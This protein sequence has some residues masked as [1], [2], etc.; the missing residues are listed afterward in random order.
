MGF[1]CR[2]QGCDVGQ[3][4]NKIVAFSFISGLRIFCISFLFLEAPKMIKNYHIWFERIMLVLYFKLFLLFLFWV[5]NPVGSS[6]SPIIL[7]QLHTCFYSSE[8]RIT[9]LYLM[10]ELDVLSTSDGGLFLLITYTGALDS[11]V[12]VS[13]MVLF[14]VGL[15]M[16]LFLF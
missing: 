6:A 12:E 7:V 4:A 8:L 3:E 16:K 5:S 2:L 13:W 14:C 11:G 15:L 9:V 1:L 10:R